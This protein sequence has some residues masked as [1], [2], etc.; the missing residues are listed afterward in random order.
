MADIKLWVST[1]IYQG[2]CRYE[3]HQSCL[4]LQSYCIRNN[5]PV[6]FHSIAGESLITRARNELVNTFLKS[7]Y[8]HYLS[9]DCDLQFEPEDVMTLIRADKPIIG[10]TYAIKSEPRRFV[11]NVLPQTSKELISEVACIG[12]GLMLIQR[13]VFD[14][15]KQGYPEDYYLSDTHPNVGERIQ[16]YFNTGIRDNR[17]FSEDYWLCD[18]YR[19]LGGKVYIAPKIHLLHYGWK[20]YD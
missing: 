19:K 1:S 2:T 15:L 18:N 16:M 17:Y 3:W 6:T 7:D 20:A 11:V 9:S 4:K 8:T 14:E 12:T 10:A 5:I 13:Y